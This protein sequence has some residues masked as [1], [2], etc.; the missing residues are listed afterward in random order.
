[1]EK[2]LV[3]IAKD[4]EGKL[5]IL[6]STLEQHIQLGWKKVEDEAVKASPEKKAAKA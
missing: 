2:E 4:G 3:T 5:K 6:A 1:M